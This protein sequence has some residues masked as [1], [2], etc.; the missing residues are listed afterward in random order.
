MNSTSCRR[1]NRQKHSIKPAIYNKKVKTR[2]KHFRFSEA[3]PQER[4]SVGWNT[5]QSRKAQDI[6]LCS[7]QRRWKEKATG[8]QLLPSASWTTTAIVDL[9]SIFPVT[10]LSKD[11]PSY[12][13]V[14]LLM[15]QFEA[16]ER[17]NKQD[18]FP[19]RIRR[20]DLKRSLASYLVH[21][22]TLN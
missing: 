12:N 2:V 4:Q 11:P 1:Y 14:L 6:C 18:L 15:L 16:T 10:T 5:A 7:P 17:Q 8:I 20:L 21:P 9:Q 19:S 13:L 3:Y 22:S